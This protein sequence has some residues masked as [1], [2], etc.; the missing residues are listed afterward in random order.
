[1]PRRLVP[2]LKYAVGAPLVFL[3][4]YFFFVSTHLLL[5]SEAGITR[6]ILGGTFGMIGVLIGGYIAWPALADQI[7]EKVT[8]RLRPMLDYLPGGRRRTDPPLLPPDGEQ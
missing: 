8:D 2:Y 4:F 5:N 1:M 6:I 3:G 7:A